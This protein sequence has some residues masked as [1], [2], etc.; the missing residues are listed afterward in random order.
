MKDKN[1]DLSEI[2]LKIKNSSMLVVVE[3]K[4]DNAAL[5]R[6]GINKE[7]IVEL[8]KK[9]IFSIIEE[10][11][12]K[13]DECTILT[14]LDRKGKELFGKLNSGLQAHGVKV[15]NSFRE[16]L[17]KRTKLRQ[18]EGITGDLDVFY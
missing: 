18:I 12:G 16:F 4:K 10:I 6:F 15:N 11:S 2:I 17:F 9:P 8:N 14:D 7:N 13:T 5:Q 1:S 3:G